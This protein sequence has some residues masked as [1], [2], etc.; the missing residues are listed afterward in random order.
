MKKQRICISGNCVASAI[1]RYLKKNKT[2]KKLYDIVLLKPIFMITP[3]DVPEYKK[4]ISECDVF[5]TQNIVGQKYINMGI[6]TVSLSKSMKP[7]AKIIKF[8]VPYFRG[9]FPE[10]FYLHDSQQNMIGECEGLPSPYH[11][12]L[13]LYGY[14]NKLSN[15]QVLDIINKPMNLNNIKKTVID[16]INEL[17]QR[18]RQLDFGISS[19]IE[20]NYQKHRLFWTVNHP[21]NFM[22]KYITTE[23]LRLLGIKRHWYNFVFL[24]KPRREYL[25]IYKTPIMQSVYQELDLSFYNKKIVYNR[26]FIDLVYKYYDKHKDL[27]DSN[28]S[29]SKNILL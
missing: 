10:Q 23:I 17:R 3:D 26:Q 25:G 9:Y 7:D 1:A 22:L 28:A 6:D 24:K 8:P 16:S 5:L 4:I 13:I 12:A 11:N 18:E 2:F 21:T 27:V 19:F 14:I 20:Q 29:V 15:N